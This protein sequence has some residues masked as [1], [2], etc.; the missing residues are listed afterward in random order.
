MDPRF[1]G[2]DGGGMGARFRGM[3]AAG[4]IPAFAG[5]TDGKEIVTPAKAGA[6]PSS[7]PRKRGPIR[8]TQPDCLLRKSP[9]DCPVTSL[10]AA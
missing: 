8:K 2:D 9:G 7:P 1:R 4:W 6:Y 3:T 5:M 10:K